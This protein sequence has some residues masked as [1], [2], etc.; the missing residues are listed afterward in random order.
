MRWFIGKCIAIPLLV[1]MAIY[2]RL[3]FIIFHADLYSYANVTVTY[4]IAV[5]L[6]GTC[7]SQQSVYVLISVP[8]FVNVIVLLPQRRFTPLS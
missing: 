4:P 1:M 7:W 3:Y 8:R 6:T 2:H 5:L